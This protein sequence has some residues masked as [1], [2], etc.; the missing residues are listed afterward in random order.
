MAMTRIVESITTS[1]GQKLTEAK[2]ANNMT[3][4]STPDGFLYTILDDPS[5]VSVRDVS[6]VVTNGLKNFRHVVLLSA[7]PLPAELTESL[8]RQKVSLVQGERFEQLLRALD[9]QDIPEMKP[10]PEEPRNVLP[11]ADKLD[12]LMRLGRDWSDNQIPALATRFYNEAAKLKPEYVPAIMGLGEAYLALG[13]LELAQSS[14]D[15]VLEL[16][17]GNV[18][19]RLGRARVH[20]LNGKVKREIEELERLIRETP[21]SIA[22]RAHLLAALVEA[23]RWQ[24]AL[25]H[26]DELIRIAPNEGRFHAMKAAVLHHLG[27]TLLA[28]K[29]ERMTLSLGVSGEDLRLVYATMHLEVPQP[30]RAAARPKTPPP[31]SKRRKR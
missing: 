9:I 10:I 11:T 18:A 7:H 13:L 30:M 15:R 16:Q 22:V 23:A 14:F 6:T 19:A 1:F 4:L 21:G 5:T 25:T 24:D 17:E 12:K 20:G 31:A 2:R 27:E 28:K 3:F 8:P 29:E 26:V